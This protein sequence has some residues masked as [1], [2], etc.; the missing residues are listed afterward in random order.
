MN[1]L[2]NSQV[3]KLICNSYVKFTFTKVSPGL[4][5]FHVF[6]QKKDILNKDINC[7]IYPT[8]I[9]NMQKIIINNIHDTYKHFVIILKK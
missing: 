8:H 3:I 9:P 2:T 7:N 4:N 5:V 6:N 1:I